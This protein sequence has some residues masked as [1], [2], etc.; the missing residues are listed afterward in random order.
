[1][2]AELS[3]M[4]KLGGVPGSASRRAQFGRSIISECARS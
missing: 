1:M 4:N 3:G 2:L